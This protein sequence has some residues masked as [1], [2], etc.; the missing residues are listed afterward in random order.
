MITAVWRAI[1]VD[2]IGFALL[3]SISAAALFGFG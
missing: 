2:V 1:G 3:V